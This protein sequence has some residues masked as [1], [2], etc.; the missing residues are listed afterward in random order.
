[1]F[2]LL[3]LIAG[4]IRDVPYVGEAGKRRSLGIPDAIMFA[5]TGDLQEQWGVKF[6]AIHFLISKAAE[7]VWR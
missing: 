4:Q 2:H 5:V 3:H 7:N 1:M 6:S